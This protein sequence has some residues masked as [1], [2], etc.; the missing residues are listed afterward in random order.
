M[1]DDIKTYLKTR[2]AKVA[3]SI[4]LE[5]KTEEAAQRQMKQSRENIADLKVRLNEIDHQ[6]QE[7][8][9]ADDEE[10]VIHMRRDKTGAGNESGGRT[11]P[12]LR[13]RHPGPTTDIVAM[14]YQCVGMDIGELADKAQALHKAKGIARTTIMKLIRRMIHEGY[15]YRE[16]TRF[17]LT[18]LCKK[19]W[20]SSPL[21]RKVA[22]NA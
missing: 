20:E 2:R 9:V 11:R 10:N 14:A 7:L 15:A 12:E 16:G 5:K 8:G 22:A 3:A 1:T 21:F 13:Y 19:A 6:M 17:F 4:A 18:P